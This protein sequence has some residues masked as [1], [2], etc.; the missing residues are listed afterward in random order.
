MYSL[1][2][3]L[4]DSNLNIENNGQTITSSFL[5]IANI[6]TFGLLVFSILSFLTTISLTIFIIMSIFISERKVVAILKIQ[7]LKKNDLYGIFSSLFL[8][9]IG[10]SILI[11]LLVT[12]ISSYLL[13]LILG[14]N[15]NVT[16]M[17][18]YLFIDKGVLTIVYLG[19]ILIIILIM[20]LLI[21]FVLMK[22]DK[23]DLALE[24]KEE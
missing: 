15:L 10:L 16:K 11:S 2:E 22:T 6:L 17:F 1:S 4:K 24:L 9:I 21:Y 5:E 23:I 20:Y 3:S 14:L 19:I 12:L 7:G 18:L 8:K 13:N